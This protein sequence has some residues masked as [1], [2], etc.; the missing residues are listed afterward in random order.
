MNVK[1]FLGTQA[2]ITSVS[3]VEKVDRQIKTD[4]TADR[5]ANGQQAYQREKRKDKMTEEQFD[6]ALALLREK[7]F[8]KEMSW[9]VLA[10]MENELKYAWVQDSNGQTIRKIS[11]YD[12]WDIF[13][14]TPAETK[15]QLLKKTA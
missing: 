2:S 14:E 10:T 1:N 5:D 12:L 9:V 15:G 4:S 8:V 3:K 7:S 6:Q 13:D 11:E